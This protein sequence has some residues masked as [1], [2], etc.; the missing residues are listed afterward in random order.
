MRRGEP[1][2]QRS[3]IEM[4]R[5]KDRS[6]ASYARPV[7][8]LCRVPRCS[9]ATPNIPPSRDV[10]PGRG[11]DSS[12][13]LGLHCM[14]VSPL[15]SSP[16]PAFLSSAYKLAAATSMSLPARRSGKVTNEDITDHTADRVSM[17]TLHLTRAPQRCVDCRSR[18]GCRC[19]AVQGGRDF[20]FW[21]AGWCRTRYPFPQ[22]C[23]TA[24][25]PACIRR[26]PRSEPGFQRTVPVGEYCV[27]TCRWEQCARARFG[28]EYSG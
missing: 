22:K 7:A 15:D 25:S 1:E 6:L 17:H 18:A 24:F 2:E 23:L 21:N 19:D 10:L 13:R 8:V 27:C 3:R 16:P 26:G 5:E 4:V 9:K 28:T 11:P 20:Q 14:R 12:G